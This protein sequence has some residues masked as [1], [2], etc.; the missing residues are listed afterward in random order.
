MSW[1]GHLSGWVPSAH[2][3]VSCGRS[4]RTA[5]TV[6]HP[7]PRPISEQGRAWP[8]WPVGL[9][10]SQRGEWASVGLLLLLGGGTH[11]RGLLLLGA[12]TCIAPLRL[13]TQSWR[14]S[15]LSPC[16]SLSHCSQALQLCLTGECAETVSRNS[17]LSRLEGPTA[18]FCIHN[19]LPSDT[20]IRSFTI[21]Q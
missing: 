12:E 20:K 11:S 10:L 19:V 6:L 7:P 18:R 8:L 14:P 16:G 21:I 17:L 3:T 1:P 5:G 13:H 15:R 9:P 2:P 4:V